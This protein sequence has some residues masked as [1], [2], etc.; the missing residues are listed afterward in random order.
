LTSTFCYMCTKLYRVI[1]KSVM[2]YVSFSHFIGRMAEPLDDCQECD[3]IP[4]ACG[5]E[6]LPVQQLPPFKL[7]KKRTQ[8]GWLPVGRVFLSDEARAQWAASQR[9]IGKG[10]R[11]AN[12][13][14]TYRCA[15]P[16]TFA[17][18]FR[19]RLRPDHHQSVYLVEQCLP[20]NE[21]AREFSAPASGKKASRGLPLVRDLCLVYLC[22]QDRLFAHVDRASQTRRDYRRRSEIE[23]RA[24]V[25]LDGYIPW[26]FSSW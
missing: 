11:S 5:V 6:V 21:H 8:R 9:G 17:C 22:P 2:A 10:Q 18:S 12:G 7:K 16:T 26:P 14:W 19:A 4:C 3:A 25:H 15:N 20:H 13:T 1:S 24:R 23:A